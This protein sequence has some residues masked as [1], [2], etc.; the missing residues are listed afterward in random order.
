MVGAEGAKN[1][2]EL[3]DSFDLA[4]MRFPIATA[5]LVIGCYQIYKIVAIGRKIEK[6]NFVE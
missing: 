1:V 2:E 4:L 6:A 5:L 3:N